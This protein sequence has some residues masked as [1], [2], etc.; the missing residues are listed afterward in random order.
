VAFEIDGNGFPLHAERGMLNADRS[1]GR[2]TM[3]LE[4]VARTLARIPDGMLGEVARRSGLS[5]RMLTRFRSGHFTDIKVSTL[6][7]VLDVVG[8]DVMLRPRVKVRPHVPRMVLSSSAPRRTL[9]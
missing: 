4:D 5:R 3:F 6:V 2:M 1:Q 8:I 7:R 9:R